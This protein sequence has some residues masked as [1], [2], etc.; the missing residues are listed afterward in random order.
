[1]GEGLE[2]FGNQIVPRSCSMLIRMIRLQHGRES[3]WVVSLFRPEEIV[4]WWA[5]SF[6]AGVSNLNT[7]KQELLNRKREEV[8]QN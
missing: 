1:M 7:G 4:R 5:I 8:Q 2:L 3:L 6:H